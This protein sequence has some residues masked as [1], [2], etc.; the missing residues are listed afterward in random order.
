[1]ASRLWRLA[2]RST[3]SCCDRGRRWS[4]MNTAVMGARMDASRIRLKMLYSFP[5]FRA[6]FTFLD[7]YR[8]P[9]CGSIPSSVRSLIQTVA[10]AT[11]WLRARR[12]LRL[13][14]RGRTLLCAAC[15]RG[16]C[17]VC[18]AWPCLSACG[19]R[20]LRS[21]GSAMR[22]WL[23]SPC[24][25]VSLPRGALPPTPAGIA[26]SCRRGPCTCA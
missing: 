25:G 17:R 2:I 8:G 20:L 22:P 19:V 11:W 7:M 14:M 23:P 5:F 21:C 12:C 13:R 10:G 16:A 4:C 24:G 15:L 18:V 9:G 1:M 6:E 26:A 3:W